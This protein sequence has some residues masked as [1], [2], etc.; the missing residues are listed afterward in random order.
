MLNPY[1]QVDDEMARRSMATSG[2]QS[3]SVESRLGAGL[4]LLSG[5]RIMEAM[6]THGLARSIGYRN[7][8][9][10][11]DAINA[12]PGLEIKYDNSI[13]APSR[14][15]EQ[16]RQL[17]RVALFHYCTEIYHEIYQRRVVQ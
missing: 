12:G 2:L 11:I 1:L 17:S 6:R 14:R 8:H 9:R 7:L 13:G 16:F 4:I 5:G 10:V 15:A 3:S